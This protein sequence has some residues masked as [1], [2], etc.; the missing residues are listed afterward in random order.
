MDLSDFPLRRCFFACLTCFL[1]TILLESWTAFDKFLQRPFYCD[2]QWLISPALHSRWKALLYTGPKVLL[3]ALACTALALSLGARFRPSLRERLG[4][5][6]RPLLLLGLS[7]A[8]VPFFAAW[9]IILILARMLGLS[10]ART[11]EKTHFSIQ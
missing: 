6:A 7:I 5:Y 10:S 2:G 9:C 8:L 11:Q 4:P 1:L 3:A